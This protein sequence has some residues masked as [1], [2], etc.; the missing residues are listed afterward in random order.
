[1]TTPAHDNV[2]DLPARPPRAV[3]LT[4]DPLLAEHVRALDP[5]IATPAIGRLPG[6]GAPLVPSTDG[7]LLLT[8]AAAA[9]DAAR[10]GVGTI[11]RTI[12]VGTDLDDAAVWGRSVDVCAAGV[13]FLPA[14]DHRLLAEIITQLGPAPTATVTPGP[15]HVDSPP[16]QAALDPPGVDPARTHEQ[17][18]DHGHALR[19]FTDADLHDPLTRWRRAAEAVDLRLPP[20]PHWPALAAQLER[21]HASGRDVP[22]LLKTHAWHNPLPEDNPGRTLADRLTIAVPG[23]GEPPLPGYQPGGRAVDPAGAANRP[24]TPISPSRPGPTPEVDR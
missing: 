12:Y 4:S 23:S 17:T 22:G 10:T 24:D 7:L 8:G 21:I 19:E 5:R 18:L 1:M 9:R 16:V 13:L 20:D 2:S 15:G 3:F 11:T 6:T 14:D